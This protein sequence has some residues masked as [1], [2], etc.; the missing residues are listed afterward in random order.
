MAVTESEFECTPR[1]LL[2]LGGKGA[3]LRKNSG[4]I[5]EGG[6]TNQGEMQAV[7]T[8]IKAK[9]SPMRE[10]AALEVIY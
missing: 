3:S 5:L 10:M 8:T 2:E 6:R 4:Q 1:A 7:G 9:I